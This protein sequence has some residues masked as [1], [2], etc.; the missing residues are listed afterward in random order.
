MRYGQWYGPGTYHPT[1]PPPPPRIEIDAVV[2]A[3]LAALALPPGTYE[4]TDDGTVAV[5]DDV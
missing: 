4:A 3:T 2:R 1:T 5:A